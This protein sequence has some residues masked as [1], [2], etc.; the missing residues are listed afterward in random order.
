MSASDGTLTIVISA[1][2]FD[3]TFFA[4]TLSAMA[5]L[6]ISDGID[7]ILSDY[8][9]LV[10][11][12]GDDFC[13]GDYNFGHGVTIDGVTWAPKLRCHTGQSRRGVLYIFFRKLLLLKGGGF[14]PI[15]NLTHYPK[16][17]PT[18]QLLMGEKEGGFLDKQSIL[19]VLMLYFYL[20][21]VTIQ[22][23]I[24]MA[25]VNIKMFTIL[26]IG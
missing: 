4:G 15:R 16:I 23:R 10:P 8:V 26:C 14:L 24:N 3:D 6:K 22:R 7:E 9:P 11:T 1:K 21:W 13:Q 5:R 17:I 20:Q 19:Q 12:I 18:Q 2:N 25:R